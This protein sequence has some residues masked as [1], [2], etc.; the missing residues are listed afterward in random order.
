M[1]LS[2]VKR[3][4]REVHVGSSTRA[5]AEDATNLQETA[6]LKAQLGRVSEQLEITKTTLDVVR[7]RAKK[8]AKHSAAGDK[9][10]ASANALQ[11]NPR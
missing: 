1:A 5:P 9:N 7:A 4:A 11:R 3:D 8:D 10:G 6:S 2:E